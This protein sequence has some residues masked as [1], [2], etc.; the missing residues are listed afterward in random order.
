M[1]GYTWDYF[2]A[3]LHSTREII[4][5]LENITN[6]QQ[7]ISANPST[8]TNCIFGDI[9][10]QVVMGDSI[11]FISKPIKRD[12]KKIILEITTRKVMYYN[13]IPLNHFYSRMYNVS[14][15]VKK[16]LND[17]EIENDIVRIIQLC[18]TIFNPDIE[19]HIIPHLNLKSKPTSEYIFERSN[20]VNLLEDISKKYNLRFHNLRKY[21][22]SINPAACIED[23]MRDSLHYD[24]IPYI[25]IKEFLIKEIC[26]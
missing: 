15:V 21:I 6:I 2:P 12:I 19:I 20:L 18:K 13:T 17:E 24:R 14:S 4:F 7:V 26:N 5:F 23:Y 10:Q 22:E 3:R 25:T 1:Y 16:T 8:I 11:K 9:Y